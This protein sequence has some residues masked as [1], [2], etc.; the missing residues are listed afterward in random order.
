MTFAVDVY[1]GPIKLGSGTATS[2]SGSISSYTTLITA[3]SGR[4]VQL[5]VTTAGTHNGK[6]WPAKITT[7]GGASLTLRDVCPF[8]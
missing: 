7:D 8:L 2:G 6:M 3:N 1:K 4:N 5:Q